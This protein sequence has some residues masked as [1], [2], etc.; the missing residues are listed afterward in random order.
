[1][2][3]DLKENNIRHIMGKSY[4][5]IFP[6]VSANVKTYA[7]DI[8]GGSAEEFSVIFFKL[9]AFKNNSFKSA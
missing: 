7:L 8:L 9:K 4:N 6:F 5:D 3:R 1:M 2:G